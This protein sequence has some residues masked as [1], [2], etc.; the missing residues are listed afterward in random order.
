[1][2]T[3]SDGT[4]AADGTTATASVPTP[5]TAT[6]PSAA[7]ANPVTLR[8]AELGVNAGISAKL[9]EDGYALDTIDEQ[10]LTDA[11]MTK[12][13]ERLS[14][15]AKLK[16]SATA[17][18]APAAAAAATAANNIGAMVLDI[19][20]DVPNE[21]SWL[22]A[23]KA[24]GVLKVEPSTVIAAVRAAL[25]HKVR[26]F[27]VP[28]LLVKRMEQ[29]AEDSEEQVG[30]VFYRLRKQLTRRSYAEIFEAL[31]GFDGS[32][33]TESRKKELL[34]RVDRFFWPALSGFYSQLKAWQ[35]AWLQGAANPAIMMSAFF[36]SSSAGH[37]VLPPGMMQPP[38]TGAVRDSADALA[39]S[40]NKVFAGVGVQITAALAYE[41][42]KIKETLASPQLPA[43][44]GVANRELMLKQLGVA[45]PPTYP[46]MEINVTRF[47]LAAL[48]LKDQSAGNDEH[49]YLGSLFMLGSQIPWDQLGGLGRAG[50]PTGLGGRPVRSGRPGGSDDSNY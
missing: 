32:Y 4:P 17:A 15:L 42:S 46:R 33:V 28:D 22:A 30:A 6:T 13:G 12:R 40:T 3:S 19:L 27:D 35:E 23:L 38:D 47:V 7:A 49:R 16:A 36:A 21:E 24:G 44:V 26:L 8:L 41:A 48:Q 9:V 25:A 50:G 29:F 2:T 37:G 20:P 11:G 43:M 5:D 18:A 39:D 1:M 34:A 10:A 31:D 14:L 45:V